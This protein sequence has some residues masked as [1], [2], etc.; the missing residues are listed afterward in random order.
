MPRMGLPDVITCEKLKS[1]S[2]TLMLDRLDESVELL[3]LDVESLCCV[4]ENF[5]T[6]VINKTFSG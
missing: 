1:H 6:G 3:S 5:S 2:L 4:A